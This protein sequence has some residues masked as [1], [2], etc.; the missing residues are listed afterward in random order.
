[1]L[2]LAAK[3]DL[4]SRPAPTGLTPDILPQ[5]RQ[6]AVDRLKSVLTREMDRLKQ[7]R[8]A[9][10]G[11]IEGIGRVQSSGGSFW[12]RLFGG[13]AVGA[14]DE[15]DAE[16]DEGLVWGGKGPFR[17]EDIEGVEIEWA[18]SALGPS[19]ATGEE[20]TGLDEV[21]EWLGSV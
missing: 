16:E 12:K 5:T 10:G 15:A 8:A 21:R 4:L 9:T 18:A 14:A 7:A 6:T 17:W 20:G 11:R 13:G 3:T 2:L 19:K 1:M